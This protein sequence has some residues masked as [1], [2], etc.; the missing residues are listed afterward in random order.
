MDLKIIFLFFVLPCLGIIFLTWL[1]RFPWSWLLKTVIVF[2]IV[3]AILAFVIELDARK[4]P[5]NSGWIMI[6]TAVFQ[7]CFLLFLL[8]ARI[9][10]WMDDKS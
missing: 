3:I 9:V 1:L 5:G 6:F 7:F 4:T 10:I 8:I 2:E